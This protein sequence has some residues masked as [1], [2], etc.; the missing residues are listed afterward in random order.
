MCACRVFRYQPE[1]TKNGEFLK[2]LVGYTGFVG[3]NLYER[4]QF[5]AGYNSKNITQAYGTKPDLLVYAGLRAEKFLANQDPAK[6]MEMILEAERN[7]AAIAPRK[8]VLI[9]TIDVFK[10]PV[11][12]D[13]A[14]P[15]DTGDLHPYGLNRYR[16]EQWVRERYPDALIIRLSAL[17]GKNIRKNFIYDYMNVIPYMLKAEKFESLLSDAPE[18]VNYYDLQA[19]GFY[20][21]DVPPEKRNKVKNIFRRLNFSA[22]NFTDSRGVYQYYPLE[23][24][25]R[26]IRIVIREGIQTWH[27]ATEPVCVSE[28]YEYLT[29]RQ[30][31]NELPGMPACYDCRTIYDDLFGGSNGYIDTKDNIM[32]MIKEF[33]GSCHADE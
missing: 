26:D 6:D 27:P 32:R 14:T 1:M 8:I 23:R 20:K 22:L 18:L 5:D 12:V 24:L 11:G 30:F 25:W 3:S 33:T 2:A 19:N 15:V 28:L 16:L 4:G 10:T 31:C 7:I 9:S 21:A 29:G 13:E 17:F